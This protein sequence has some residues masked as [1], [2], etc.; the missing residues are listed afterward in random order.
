MT[1]RLIYATLW[2]VVLSMVLGMVWHFLLFEELYNSLGIYNRTE[3]IIALGFAS[4][5]I[6]G[7]LMAYLYPFYSRNGSSIGKG[8]RFGLMMG[9]FLFSVSTLAN[10]AK[11]EVASMSSWI[12]VQLA[13]HAFQFIAAGAGIGFIYKAR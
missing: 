3:P 8:I 6:Q 5:I 4:M 12:T 10:A 1:K 9:L 13:F 7:L 11:I 2:Y